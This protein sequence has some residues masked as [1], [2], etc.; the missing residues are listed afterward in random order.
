M[1]IT[2]N[3]ES[4][5]ASSET[6]FSM[7]TDCRRFGKFL[8]EQ[9]KEVEMTEDYCKFSFQGVATLKLTIT[10][11]IPF[12]KI[13]F[14]AGNDHNIPAAFTLNITDRDT[15]CEVW[16]EAEMEIPVFANSIVKKPLQQ[17]TDAVAVKIKNEAEKKA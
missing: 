13:V 7:A 9:T 1:K 11:K 14:K 12:S 3:K 10:E 6:I 15:H 5:N 8:P 17:F 2:G 4:V 16:I